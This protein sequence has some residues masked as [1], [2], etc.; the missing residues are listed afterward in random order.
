VTVRNWSVRRHRPRPRTLGAT[1]AAAIGLA[2]VGLLSG[3]VAIAGGLG[4]HAISLR[5]GY[6][7]SW[8]IPAV[9]ATAAPA[10][11]APPKVYPPTKLRIPS[12]SV[13]TALQPLG[14]DANGQLETP[15]YTDAG[16]Y[17]GGTDPGDVGPAVIAGHYDAKTPNTPSVFYRLDA[18]E[19]GAT[20][21]VQR[22]GKWLTFTVT[23]VASYR[24]NAFP[25]E[26]VYGPTPTPELRLITCGG[27][28]SA[29]SGT[30]VDDTVVYAAET[31]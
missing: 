10:A 16:W 1:R 20:I 14:L 5:T 18:L 22:R 24:Q 23:Q 4:V 15:K 17:S 3:A 13:N 7:E 28:F 19:V 8:D 21:Q 30:Y 9:V 31:P 11:P 12:I 29:A 2:V 25:T 26:L 6:T 27:A